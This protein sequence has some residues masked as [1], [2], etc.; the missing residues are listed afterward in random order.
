M[1]QQ[2]GFLLTGWDQSIDDNSWTPGELLLAGRPSGQDAPFHRCR[3]SDLCPATSSHALPH[4]SSFPPTRAVPGNVNIF[5]ARDEAVTNCSFTHLGAAGHVVANSSQ[6]VDVFSST[7]Q[8][9]SCG[10]LRVGQVRCPLQGTPL[11][12]PRSLLLPRP[13]PS[14]SSPGQV[15]NVLVTDPAL[16][17]SDV[18]VSDN[19]FVDVAV[20]YRDCS[21]ASSSCGDGC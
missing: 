8:D 9:V 13:S 18:N 21:G 10:G 14:P 15:D 1:S 2:S 11:A 12:P 4:P 19:L 7:F 3:P 17:T 20:E 16:W 6:Q 5:N